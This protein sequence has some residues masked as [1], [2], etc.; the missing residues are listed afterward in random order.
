MSNNQLSPE[1]MARLILRLGKGADNALGNEFG[2]SR[3][4]VG[5]LRKTRNIP[6]YKPE[7]RTGNKVVMTATVTKADERETKQAMKKTGHKK[8]S[9]YVRTAIR[10]KNKEVLG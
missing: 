3:Q 5:D 6:V 9:G 2:I 4:R 1:D 8:R 7:F 10:E